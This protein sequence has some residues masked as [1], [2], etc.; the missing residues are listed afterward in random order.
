[1][2][3]LREY[4]NLFIIQNIVGYN[5][6]IR[7]VVFLSLVYTSFRSKPLLRELYDTCHVTSVYHL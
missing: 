7:V 4:F 3:I 1:M 2:K 5:K 6:E